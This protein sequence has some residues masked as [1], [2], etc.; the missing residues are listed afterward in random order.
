MSIAIDSISLA[1]VDD[2]AK[3]EQG[4]QGEKGETGDRGAKMALANVKYGNN[5]YYGGYSEAQLAAIVGNKASDNFAITNVSDFQIGDLALCKCVASDTKRATYLIGKITKL[6]AS[7]I[8]VAIIGQTAGLNGAAGNGVKS[9]TIDYQIAADGTTKPTTWQETIPTTTAEKPYLWSRTTIN[10]TDG[11]SSVTYSVGGQIV[12]AEEL[13]E[14]TATTLRNESESLKADVTDGYNDAIHILETSMKDTYSTIDALKT[15]SDNVD[16]NVAALG[17]N[18]KDL[19]TTL[20][21]QITAVDADLQLKYGELT[22]YFT[23]GKDLTIGKTD[24][25]YTVV[26]SNDKYSMNYNQQAILWFDGTGKGHIP[27]LNVP[28]NFSFLGYTFTKDDSGNV[29][30]GYTG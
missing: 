27:S 26:I 29:N 25:P 30:L 5:D 9:S 16:T 22:S 19:S 13:I 2:G 14:T 4:I 12:A 6:L 17:G 24:S 23:F 8:N 1:R 11:T 10:Y 3:G 15:L 28:D 18:I 20:S 21:G 7:S